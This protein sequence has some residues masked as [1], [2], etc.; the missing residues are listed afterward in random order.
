MKTTFIATGDS[1]ITRRLPEA[2]YSGLDELTELISR[3]DVRFANLEITFH[4]QEGWPAASSGGTWAMTD[5]EMLDEIARYDFNLYNTANNHSGD[6]GQEGCA[7]TIRHLNERKMLFAGTGMSLEEASRAVYLETPEARVAMIGITSTF[8]PAAAAGGR[9]GEMVGRP[10]LNPLRHKT[11]CHVTPEHFAMAEALAKTTLINWPIE[12]K[13]SCGY[14]APFPEG[15]MPFG[16]LNFVR[17]DKEYIETIPHSDDVER[18][19]AEI[20]EARLQADLVIVSI[21]GHE[22]TGKDTTTP[23][24]FLETFA[25][26]CV[27][28]GAS[29]VIG[30]GPHELRGIE[31]YRGAPIFYSIG[32]FIFES[33]TTALQPSDAYKSMHLPIDTKVGAYMSNRSR[34]DTIG[35]PTM[36]NI[37]RAVIPSWTI[38]DGRLTS[39]TCYP[40]ELGM[41]KSRAQRG[42]PRL[43]HDEDTLL[44]LK[45]LSERYGTVMTIRDG[46]AHITL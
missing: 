1:F 35:F 46:A 22:M 8:D 13:I 19:L 34:N 30:H 3:H 7:A 6:F 41:G 21:H 25:R 11:V 12:H 39:V 40:I 9:T 2:G 15:T 45:A 16:K 42:I 32:N 18:T 24:Q 4:R 28:A 36:K 5:P 26:A 14:A 31:I 38:E 23:A 37:W 33:E 27:D 10:G 44:Y 20:Q 29:A 17:D 43:S